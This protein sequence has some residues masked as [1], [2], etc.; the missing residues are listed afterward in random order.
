MVKVKGNNM[1]LDKN[2]NDTTHF[3]KLKFSNDARNILDNKILVQNYATLYKTTGGSKATNIAENFVNK[4]INNDQLKVYLDILDID[5]T[6]NISVTTLFPTALIFGDKPFLKFVK[7]FKKLKQ[8]K[9]SIPLI[10]NNILKQY[11]DSHNNVQLSISIN[12]LVPLGFLMSIYKTYKQKK[13]QAG[14]SLSRLFVGQNV[15]VGDFQLV[16]RYYNGQTIPNNIY[17]PQT[18]YGQHNRQ[19]SYYNPEIQTFNSLNLDSTLPFPQGYGIKVDV[20][21]IEN[22]DNVSQV[23]AIKN[24]SIIGSEDLNNSVNLVMPTSMS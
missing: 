2:L 22:I 10:D 1:Y 23:N 6:N 4:F 16:H 9:G 11:L 15:P 14:G 19:F 24:D 21:S 7:Y 20:P 17:A 18:S 13:K 3:N 5:N 12:T 8:D